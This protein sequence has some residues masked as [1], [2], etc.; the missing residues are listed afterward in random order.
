MDLGAFFADI[1]ATY[2]RKLGFDSH[3]QIR[4][5]EAGMLL[6]EHVPSGL[7]IQGSGGK[8]LATFTPWVGVFDPDETV[9]PQHGV[10]VV[11]LFGEDDPPRQRTPQ[12]DPRR[13]RAIRR[14]VR[15]R[16]P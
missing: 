16:P 8:G 7:L 14:T 13:H 15:L 9:S 4:L 10:Y 2:D 1:A 3:A 5:K 11:Y 12:C 6:A